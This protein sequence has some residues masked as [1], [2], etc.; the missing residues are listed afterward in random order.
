MNFTSRILYL[1][2]FLFLGSQVQAQCP[3]IIGGD[4]LPSNN[5]RWVSC[6]GGAFN[7]FIQ[8]NQAIGSYIISWGDGTANNTGASIGAAGFV[9]HNYAAAQANYTVTITETSTG[10]VIS[11]TV[12]M[13]EAVN[14]AIQIPLGGVT[15]VCAPGTMS[16]T[17]ASTN[18]SSNTNFIW[19]FGDG[20]APVPFNSTN[21]GAI[22]SHT[23][24]RNTVNCVTTVTLSAENFC[25][26]GTPTVASFNPI[27]VYDIDD[28]QI[29]ASAT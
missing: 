19:T 16:F 25:S 18:V 5:P 14:S 21:A 24:Q 9:S 17:N 8:G 7:L 15:A 3:Q 28:A 11:G 13:E 27:Q 10:C 29:T 6:S 26:F 20:S 23:F 1:L 4:G 22:V 2:L 12:I